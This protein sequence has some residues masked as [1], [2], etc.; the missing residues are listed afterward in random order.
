MTKRTVQDLADAELRGKRALVRG[1]F[2]VPMD[3]SGHVSDDTRMRA[4]IP[5]I[6]L[7]LQRG[8]RV[9][10]LLS[11]LGR[12]RG[13]PEAQY[14][15]EPVAKHLATLVRAP[16]RFVNLTVG[17]KAV[18]ATRDAPDGTILLMENTRFAPGEERNDPAFARQLAELGDLYVNDAFGSAHRAH[19]STE[20][21]IESVLCPA[22]RPSGARRCAA[23]SVLR[24]R[25]S[26]HGA[27]QGATC[28]D[29]RLRV[30]E[31]AA[32]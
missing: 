28:T 21:V 24:G 11:H 4:A 19:A 32:V 20:G 2:N 29:C 10:V 30:R 14:S 27:P 26:G 12:P 31:A 1:D 15:L 17:E 8:A 25:D 5:T 3:A 23:P 6:E 16:V 18:A 9:V 7:L 13:K 22:T